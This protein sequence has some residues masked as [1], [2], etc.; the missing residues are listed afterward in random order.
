MVRKYPPPDVCRITCARIMAR[1]N[2][3]YLQEEV[4][5]V[6]ITEMSTLNRFAETITVFACL[7]D[8]KRN[9]W[10]ARQLGEAH[11]EVE[12]SRRAY[13]LSLGIHFPQKCPEIM[14]LRGM[15]RKIPHTNLST[16]R[17]QTSSDPTYPTVTRRPEQPI[18]ATRNPQ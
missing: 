7:V 8:P 16:T 4:L 10:G 6:K 2:E 5:Y 13:L 18:R 3:E 12:I 15:C 11:R 14:L 17:G 9:G 1:R